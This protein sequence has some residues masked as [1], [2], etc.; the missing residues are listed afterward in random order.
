V[1][2]DTYV[3]EDGLCQTVMGGE[4]LGPGEDAGT[5]GVGLGLGGGWV[6]GSAPSYR[7]RGRWS[8]EGGCGMGDWWRGNQEVGY[9]IRCKQME[10]LI[11]K[12]RK[13]LVRAYGCEFP[14]HLRK[15]LHILKTD[16]SAMCLM[17]VLLSCYELLFGYFF[18]SL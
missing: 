8:V 1:A 10:W 17:G 12:E 7:Q 13:K 3:A 9:H 11:K 6:G 18:Q 5:V 15:D 4:A 16:I 2:P 14:T